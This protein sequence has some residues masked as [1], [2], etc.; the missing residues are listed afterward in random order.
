[1][2]K[3]GSL[4][5]RLGKVGQLTKKSGKLVEHFT[6]VKSICSQ[7]YYKILVIANKEKRIGNMEKAFVPNIHPNCIHC[8]KIIL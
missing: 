1:M 5:I 3:N 4:R 8:E 7:E 2:K 6:E